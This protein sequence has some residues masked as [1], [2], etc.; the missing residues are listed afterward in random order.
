MTGIVGRRGITA[1]LGTVGFKGIATGGG[2]PVWTPASLTNLL[3]WYNIY[4]LSKMWTTSDKTT[5]VAADGDPVG[6]I[7]DSSGNG[8]HIQQTVSANRPIFRTSGGLN[9]LEYNGAT[10]NRWLQSVNTVDQSSSQNLTVC[11]GVTVDVNAVMVIAETSASYSINNGAWLFYTDT[12]RYQILAKGSSA[13]N[14]SNGAISAVIAAPN[15]RV[16]VG[17][18]P[19]AS[20]NLI[21]TNQTEVASVTNTKGAIDYGN[22]TLFIGRRNGASL[23]LD[24][25]IYSLFAYTDIKSGA[26]LTAIEEYIAEKSGVTL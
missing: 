2:A 21:R 13:P 15:T 8:H 1:Q 14:A 6:Y 26:D 18:A 16:V 24:G 9:W 7:E 23:P 11:T 5:N 22:Y 3:W 19:M 12:Q 25:N 20:N 10:S 17:L 4:D